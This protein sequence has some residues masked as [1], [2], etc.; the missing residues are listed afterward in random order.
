[1]KDIQKRDSNKMQHVFNESLI[2]VDS[3]T[4]GAALCRRQFQALWG[5]KP[6]SFFSAEDSD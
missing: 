1:M 6:L 3:S 2:K 4:V 5:H